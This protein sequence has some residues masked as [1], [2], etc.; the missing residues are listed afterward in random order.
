MPVA[1]CFLPW[2]QPALRVV[3]EKVLAPVAGSL[4]WNLQQTLCVFPSAR[5]SQQFLGELVECAERRA[6]VLAPPVRTTTGGLDAHLL[7]NDGALASDWESRLALASA[8]RDV[9]SD[10]L[11]AVLRRP[12]EPEDWPNWLAIAGAL[13]QLRETL[14]AHRVFLSRTTLSPDLF[15]SDVER[16]R[17]GVLAKLE[18]IYLNRLSKINKMDVFCHREEALSA[19]RANWDGAIC[20]IGTVDLN[21]AQQALVRRAADNGASVTA[22]IPAPEELAAGFDDLG[23]LNSEFWNDRPIRIDDEQI[24]FAD[25]PAAQA[26]AVL[27]AIA[28]VSDKYLAD[29]IKI[30]ANDPAVRDRIEIDAPRVGAAVRSLRGRPARTSPPVRLLEAV[31]EYAKGRGAAA[32]ASL[33]R[34]PDFI[35]WLARRRVIRS[36]EDVQ[37]ALKD[38]D[39]FRAQNVPACLDAERISA[40]NIASICRWIEA[41]ESIARGWPASRADLKSWM[42]AFADAMVELYG[43]RPIADGPE[44]ELYREALEAI[45]AAAR[46]LFATS[47][48]LCSELSGEEAFELLAEQLGPLS[49]ESSPSGRI[50]LVG[51]LD[52]LLEPAP[53]LLVTGM[54]EGFVP[55]PVETE[56][57]LTPAVR[58]ALNIAGSAHREARDRFALTS[59]LA[60]HESVSFFAGRRSPTDDPLL[61]SRLLL[62]TDAAT[63]ASRLLR[64]FSK[65]GVVPR[66]PR[67]DAP[68]VSIVIPQPEPAEPIDTLSV[69]GFRD[70]LTCPYR[71]YLKHV[72]RIERIDDDALELNPLGVGILAHAVLEQFARSDTKDSTDPEEIRSFLSRE[73]DRRYKAFCVP[74]LAAVRIQIELLRPRLNRFAEVQAQWAADGWRIL[75]PEVGPQTQGERA[76]FPVDGK[77]FFLRGRIDRIDIHRET[78]E[79]AILDY[80]TGDKGQGPHEVHYSRRDAVWRNLQLPL[81]RHLLACIDLPVEA[82]SSIDRGALRVGYVLLPKDL[83]NVQFALAEWTREELESADEAARDVVRAIRARRFWPPNPDARKQMPDYRR[84]CQEE[85]LLDES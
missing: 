84:I 72:R 31:V 26:R 54:N 35:D 43:D 52:L 36:N 17:W 14:A 80:K 66:I 13:G 79:L 10:D 23:V 56:V 15:A 74:P 76:P 37:R 7:P 68:R 20:L 6:A 25:D 12:P 27:A 3:A 39:S 21:P 28:R 2:N 5:A 75:T 51:W 82:Q 85:V 71:F 33:A 24:E 11:A 73:L 16:R 64:F 49:S 48:P 78:G 83:S 50:E 47:S 60:S 19:G 53:C 57:F 46:S 1:R 62:A 34:H 18:E 8:L 22:Y 65:D 70:Y 30:V 44:D 59:I 9:N 81:Y 69:T 63:R 38:L 55:E 58:S 41:A 77:P 29:E 40:A 4:D 32:F 42:Q 45:A 61:P 67:S